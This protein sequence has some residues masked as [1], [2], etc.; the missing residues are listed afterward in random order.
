M[1]TATKRRGV[2]Y[3][4]QTSVFEQNGTTFKRERER[5]RETFVSVSKKR[6]FFSFPLH[7]LA[8]AFARICARI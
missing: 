2:F 1:V 4:S 7:F 6:I 8:R 5:E 3:I